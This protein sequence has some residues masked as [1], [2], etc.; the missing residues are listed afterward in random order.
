MAGLSAEASYAGPELGG[1]RGRQAKGSACRPVPMMLS[2][3]KEATTHTGLAISLILCIAAAGCCWSTIQRVHV[4][5]EMTWECA[6]DR[7]MK[8]YPQAQPV[9]F[10]FVENPTYYELIFGR[11][12]CDQLRRSSK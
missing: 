7:A 10:R 4:D 5:K 1:D 2:V 11:G 9:R 6:P 3:A 8:E 12:L